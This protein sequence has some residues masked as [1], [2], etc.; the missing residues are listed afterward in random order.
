MIGWGGYVALQ[1]TKVW[2]VQNEKESERK[3]HLRED[4]IWLQRER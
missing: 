1:R 3:I 4:E 2:R